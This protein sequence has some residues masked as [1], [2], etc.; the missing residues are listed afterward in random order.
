[1]TKGHKYY[2]TIKIKSD[3]TNPVGFQNYLFLDLSDKTSSAEFTRLSVIGTCTESGNVL[4]Q[5]LSP[6]ATDY[7][8]VKNSFMLFDLTLLFGAGNEPTAEQFEAM[9]PAESYPYSTGVIASS[10]TDTITAGAETITTSF[11]ALYAAMAAYDYIDVNLEQT[12][13][14]IAVI[15]LSVL[16]FRKNADNLFF[17]S[18]PLNAKVSGTFNDVPNNI[19]DVYE[20][21]TLNALFKG[22]KGITTQPVNGKTVW[23]YDNAYD[24][25]EKLVEALSA[26]RATLHYEVATPIIE[27]VTIPEALQEW[28]PVEPGGTVTFRNADESKQLAVPNAVSWVR[29]LDEVE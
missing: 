15:N 22:A 27:P 8:I 2:Q 17:A 24:T 3:G 11:P 9:F 18:L 10:R 26:V 14:N 28:L 20:T 7:Q 6:N 19:C 16:D 23:I 1:M 12:H 25:P 4:V 5:L 29:K 13:R 21:M